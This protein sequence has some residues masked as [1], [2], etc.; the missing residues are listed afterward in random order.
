MISEADALAAILGRVNA[1]PARH[2]PLSDSM[3]LFAAKSFSATSPLPAFDN[4]AMDGYAI[5]SADLVAGKRLRLMAEQPAGLDKNLKVQPG[6]TVRIFTGAP[7]PT[8]TAAVVM[9]EE[10]E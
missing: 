2:L 6:E 7:V 5:S 4:S 1:L 3:G 8:G 10:V 9:Q